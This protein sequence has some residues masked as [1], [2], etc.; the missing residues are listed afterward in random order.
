MVLKDLDDKEG[1]LHLS[2]NTQ[3]QQVV[4]KR[5]GVVDV[6]SITMWRSQRYWYM[7]KSKATK[8][9]HLHFPTIVYREPNYKTGA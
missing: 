4:P 2:T 8:D 5:G 6:V 7:C 1:D 9:Q 3:G